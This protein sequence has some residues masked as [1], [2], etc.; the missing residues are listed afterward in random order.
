M[1]AEPISKNLTIPISSFVFV[2]MEKKVHLSVRPSPN[3]PTY[4]KGVNSM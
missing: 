2:K 4:G 1:K 3:S